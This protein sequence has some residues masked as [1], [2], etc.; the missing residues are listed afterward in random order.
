ML[1]THHLREN[2]KNPLILFWDFF[3]FC[4]GL[5]KKKSSL[6]WSVSNHAFITLLLYLAGIMLDEIVSGRENDEVL[7][8][9]TS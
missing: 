6:T 7:W 1:Q 2:A 4:L 5:L 3:C 9:C 8:T